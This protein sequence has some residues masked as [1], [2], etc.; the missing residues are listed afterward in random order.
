MMGTR[1]VTCDSGHCSRG[2]AGATHSM[3]ASAQVTAPGAIISMIVA[4]STRPNRQNRSRCSRISV[5]L[6]GGCRFS[7]R[8]LYVGN[9][10]WKA[11]CA[12]GSLRHTTTRRG[13]PA[14]VSCIQQRPAPYVSGQIGLRHKAS[15]TA[16]GASGR[17][18][19]Q[20]VVQ[21]MALHVA[22]HMSYTNSTATKL[23]IATQ[24]HRIVTLAT[25]PKLHA[26]S[27][28]RKK[29]HHARVTAPKTR[30]AAKA[31]PFGYYQAAPGNVPRITVASVLR[32]NKSGSCSR[33]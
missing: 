31:K 19:Y 23:A 18:L 1:R 17:N 12:G 27:N 20:G 16:R 21:T 9:C 4:A 11:D 28:T 15:T 24:G 30:R 3:R 5:P 6:V 25:V 13:A 10:L 14:V 2:R 8:C 33:T 22:H 7:L 32:A 29:P 26:T